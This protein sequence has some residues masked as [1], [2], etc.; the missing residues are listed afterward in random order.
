M[1]T[2]LTLI[3]WNDRFQ[4]HRI[5]FCVV[6]VFRYDVNPNGKRPQLQ[7]QKNV[8][9]SSDWTDVALEVPDDNDTVK[10]QQMLIVEAPPKPPPR[11]HKKGLREKIESVAKSGLQALNINN[12]KPVDEPLFI[13]K[14]IDY[15]CP[16]DDHDHAHHNI[17]HKRKNEI[18]FPKG[19]PKLSD[20]IAK[21]RKNLSLI[22]LPNYNELKFSIANTDRQKRNSISS[23][24]DEC[25][26]LSIAGG[27]KDTYMA[28]C[29]SFGSILPNQILEKLKQP[30]TPADIE[31]DDSFGHLEDWDLKIIED[32]N[33]KDASLP[34]ARKIPKI[35]TE[36]L[37]NIEN[38]IVKEEDIRPVPPVRRGDSLIKKMNRTT[39]ETQ[40]K[41][42]NQQLPIIRAA[43]LPME[44]EEGRVEHS[45]L[46]KILE[47]FSIKDKQNEINEMNELNDINRSVNEVKFVP[48]L[49]IENDKKCFTTH[50]VEDFLKAERTS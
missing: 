1:V 38:M 12:K 9:K 4:Y 7:K 31:S 30:K 34:R 15:S 37:N 33:P 45:S 46:M 5:K 17:N 13:K 29:R 28:R 16:H 3:N 49:I 19:T 50:P 44:D 39:N 48:Q 21:R 22:S 20:K 35:E 8:S 26:K 32:Y 42:Q 11:K 25:K 43:Q 18:K 2:N 6:F 23:L 27:K 41:E 14:T 10:K 24:P 47:E 40:P 36:L